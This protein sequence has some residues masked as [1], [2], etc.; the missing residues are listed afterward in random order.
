LVN[1]ACDCAE[2]TVTI[3]IFIGEKWRM[4]MIDLVLV[5]LS[6]KIIYMMHYQMRVNHF[7]FWILS[8]IE[9]RLNEMMK[10]LKQLTKK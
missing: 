3:S 6:V 9:F 2:N 4:L 10:R 1:A 7:E 5:T 8:S